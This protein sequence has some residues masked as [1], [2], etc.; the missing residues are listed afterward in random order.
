MA[1]YDENLCILF[2]CFPLDT[3]IQDFSFQSISIRHYSR[4]DQHPE[5]NH[6]MRRV[7]MR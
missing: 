2:N 6:S 1:V 7:M 3:R 5:N 4:Q